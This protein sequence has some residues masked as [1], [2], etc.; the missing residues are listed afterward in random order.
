MTPDIVS[1]NP[2]IVEFYQ[3]SSPDNPSLVCGRTC[4]ITL[5]RDKKRLIWI[6]EISYEAGDDFGMEEEESVLEVI[7]IGSLYSACSNVLKYDMPNNFKL[8]WGPISYTAMMEHVVSMDIKLHAAWCR[9]LARFSAA[10]EE[11]GYH[12]ERSK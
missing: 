7:E 3:S 1:E 10:I 5:K 2:H 8:T 6:L 4:G 12:W 9:E 11:N